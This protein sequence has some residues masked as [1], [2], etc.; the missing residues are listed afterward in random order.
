MGTSGY[1]LKKNEYY[2]LEKIVEDVKNAVSKASLY[3]NEENIQ[4]YKDNRFSIYLSVFDKTAFYLDDD[5]WGN[6][7]VD[8]GQCFLFY[9]KCKDDNYESE[10]QFDW[11]VKD[12]K[13]RKVS[14]I[15]E[16]RG[17]EEITFKFIHEYLKL[18]PQDY[19]WV[20]DDWVYNLE[21]M[22]RLSKS[23]FNENWCYIKSST[24]LDNFS[25]KLKEN[26]VLI[27]MS[28]LQ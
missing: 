15:E 27:E 18:N 7:E 23:P 21:D 24:T 8:Q 13:L 5:D 4:K 1:I 3:R 20:E 9:I 25:H 17:C 14:Y 26:I 28:I 22:E 6:E 11:V 2:V 10:T 19:F 16:I 12:G